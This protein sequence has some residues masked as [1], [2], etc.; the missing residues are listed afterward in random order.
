MDLQIVISVV[1]IIASCGVAW[2]V[3]K[4]QLK[5]FEERLDALETDNKTNRELLIEIK[6]KVDLLL[7]GS[8]KKHHK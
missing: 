3:V 8:I 7:E 4:Q 1:T 6:T 5:Q 2:G